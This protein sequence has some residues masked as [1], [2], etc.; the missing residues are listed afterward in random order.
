M[1]FNFNLMQPD[2]SRNATNPTQ[3][4][5][6]PYIK[7]TTL[8]HPKQA[9]AIVKCP[10]GVGARKFEASEVGK[11]EGRKSLNFRR[12]SCSTYVSTWVGFIYILDSSNFSSFNFDLVRHLQLE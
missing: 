1:T 5:K 12:L 3:L 2:D 8:S 10:N 6:Q 4:E 7:K 9:K 11:S